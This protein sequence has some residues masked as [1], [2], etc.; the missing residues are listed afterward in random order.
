MGPGPSV[1]NVGVALA[2]L[3][4]SI[5]HPVDILATVGETIADE[6]PEIREDMLDACRDSR[7]AA[8]I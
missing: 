6:N 3:G 5:C 7:A 4:R 8:G 1:D 2:K